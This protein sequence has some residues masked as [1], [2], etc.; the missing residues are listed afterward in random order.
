MMYFVHH[1]RMRSEKVQLQSTVKRT[2]SLF[3]KLILVLIITLSACK[4]TPIPN[5]IE[6]A[7]ECNNIDSVVTFIKSY[8]KD[9][10]SSFISKI[11]SRWRIEGKSS[12]A[13]SLIDKV[14]FE[15][16]PSSKFYTANLLDKAFVLLTQQKIDSCESIIYHFPVKKVVEEWKDTFL[17]VYYYN[18]FGSFW[19]YKGD[20]NKANQNFETGYRFSLKYNQH[21]EAE[22]FANNLGALNY[23]LGRI[24]TAITY[25]LQSYDYVSQRKGSNPVLTNNIASILLAQF[26]PREA[27]EYVQKC[28]TELDI[29]DKSYNGILVKLNYVKILQN[30]NQFQKA[31]T[32]IKLL[33]TVTIPSVFELD[34]FF[35][36][37]NQLNF[38]NHLLLPNFVIKNQKFLQKNKY[39]LLT[40]YPRGLS[41][42]LNEFPNLAKTVGYSLRDIDA[43]N[44]N[45]ASYLQKYSFYKILANQAWVDKQL[46]NY[47][48]FSNKAD[49]YFAQ[50]YTYKD[51]IGLDDISN[52][53][54]NIEFFKE[55]NTVKA[56]RDQQNKI[57]LL[58]RLVMVGL[59]LIFISLIILFY[60][61]QKLQKG[62]SIVLDLELQKANFNSEKLKFENEINS[63]MTAMSKIMMER[64]QNF[65]LRLKNSQFSK[66]PEIIQIRKEIEEMTNIHI[67]SDVEV[68]ETTNSMKFD[69]LW[70]NQAF[71]ELTPTYKKILM[72]SVEGFRPKEIAQLMNISYSHVRNSRAHLKKLIVA[73]GYQDFEQLV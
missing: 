13:D 48:S 4:Q 36:K 55:L 67:D 60:Y 30:L 69:H 42:L 26:K 21:I 40:E 62:K 35:I 17:T 16:Q 66:D 1:M 52:R 61:R 15:L 43:L 70:E 25:F 10:P 24:Q 23:K 50:Y 2:N 41:I 29:K 73:E 44:E 57:I 38:E 49:N 53:I 20:Y 54:K 59:I 8:E 34:R 68:K 27:L 39:Q 3:Y 31:S 45:N 72:L 63:K 28:S 71:N 14:Y 22:R 46:E 12:R 9:I 7:K 11:G 5:Y 32:L 37:T 65:A 51:S 33:D 47:H 58:E 19:Y 56:E 64:T 18:V 6:Y